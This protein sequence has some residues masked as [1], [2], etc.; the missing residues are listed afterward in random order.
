MFNFSI[1]LDSVNNFTSPADFLNYL[2]KQ[3]IKNSNTISLIGKVVLKRAF[4]KCLG[5]KEDFKKIE[6]KKLKSGRPIVKIKDRNLKKMFKNKKIVASIS[7]TK[8]IA[9]AVCLIYER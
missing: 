6:I 8:D 5:I 1:E 2:S 9:I 3:E 7:H 4:F